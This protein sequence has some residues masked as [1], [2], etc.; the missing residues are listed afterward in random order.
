VYLTDRR[1]VRA[2]GKRHHRNIRAFPVRLATTVWIFL[3]SP[4]TLS[5]QSARL[6]LK[7]KSRRLASDL[8]NWTASVIA[9]FKSKGSLKASSLP[10]SRRVRSCG[11]QVI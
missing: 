8:Y 6:R 3:Q 11:R 5:G 2:G 1:S 9:A 7:A 10:L 4:T